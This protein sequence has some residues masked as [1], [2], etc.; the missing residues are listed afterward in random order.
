MLSTLQLVRT[1]K[2]ITSHTHSYSHTQTHTH[3]FEHSNT[4]VLGSP[5]KKKKNFLILTEI[6]SRLGHESLR[7]I[8][9]IRKEVTVKSS[10]ACAY[11]LFSS[12][13]RG[14]CAL[15]ADREPGREKGGRRV[16]L[17]IPRCLASRRPVDLLAKCTLS[18]HRVSPALN[19]SP[20]V[21]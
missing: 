19:E 5:E 7:N 3:G 9:R 16:D 13:D 10:G 17:K 11:F 2:N 20:Y 14:P 12:R 6:P 8:C 21:R 15:G 18:C 1:N 4:L